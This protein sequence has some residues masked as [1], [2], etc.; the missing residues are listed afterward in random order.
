MP[1]FFG[2]LR[3]SFLRKKILQQLDQRVPGAYT[4]PLCQAF[5]VRRRE[6]T[7]LNGKDFDCFSG[8]PVQKRQL[9]AVMPRTSQDRSSAKS[10]FF[11][12]FSIASYGCLLSDSISRILWFINKLGLSFLARICYSCMNGSVPCERFPTRNDSSRRR[13]GYRRYP[14]GK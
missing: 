1:E 7:G 13:P 8:F 2:R 9:S 11:T 4:D 10:A 5:L 12:F 3:R 14:N 6:Q